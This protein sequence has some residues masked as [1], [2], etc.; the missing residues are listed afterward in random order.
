MDDDTRAALAVERLGRQR[1]EA[2]LKQFGD[3]GASEVQLLPLDRPPLGEDIAVEV[4]TRTFLAPTVPD[5]EMLHAACE[6][7]RTTHL[8]AWRRG[9]VG[10]GARAAYEVA[11]LLGLLEA[12]Q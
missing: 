10:D 4:V 9:E 1:A 12:G 11:R 5:A 2:A 6:Y 7:L 3:L 8:P